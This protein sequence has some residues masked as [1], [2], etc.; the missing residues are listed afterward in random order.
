MLPNYSV[1]QGC[2]VVL[3]SSHSVPKC[4]LPV[5]S[6]F[7]VGG[8]SFGVGNFHLTVSTVA[9]CWCFCCSLNDE[10][11]MYEGPLCLMAIMTSTQ[12]IIHISFVLL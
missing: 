5:C 10:I 11:R 2:L 4:R 8:S 3:Q 7:G 1:T 9:V 12:G 6:M